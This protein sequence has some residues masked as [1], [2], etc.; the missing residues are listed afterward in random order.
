MYTFQEKKTRQIILW[1]T[2]WCRNY[3]LFSLNFFLFSASADISLSHEP[4]EETSSVIRKRKNNRRLSPDSDLDDFE[5]ISGD[6]LAEVSPW[7]LKKEIWKEKHLLR[8]VLYYH[9][10][11]WV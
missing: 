1:I 2:I 9:T 6:E 11:L 7:V 5:M 4:I 10:Q 3:Y 8:N